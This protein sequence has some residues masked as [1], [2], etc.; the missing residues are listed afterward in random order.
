MFN[1]KY[2]Y[3][4]PDHFSPSGSEIHINEGWIYEDGDLKFVE[5]DKVPLYAK[6]QAERDLVELKAIL[7]RYEAGDDT[8]LDRVTGMYIDTIDM[9][10]NYMELY[11]AVSKANDIFAAMPTDIKEK[12]NNNP[13]TFWK[14]YGTTGFDDVVNAYRSDQLSKYGMVDTEPIDSVKAMN[15]DYKKA[16][17]DMSK[18]VIP[19]KGAE[20]NE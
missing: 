16:V 13:A 3:K 18:K 10:T 15:E 8:A 19:E 7:E 5:K 1:N 11:S 12:Y 2:E 20:V 17:D 6:I 9:P 4:R 14:N